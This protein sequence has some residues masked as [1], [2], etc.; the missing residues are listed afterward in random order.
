MTKNVLREPS[1]QDLWREEFG[2]VWSRYWRFLCGPPL[3]LGLAALLFPL[4][5]YRGTAQ[6]AVSNLL[7]FTFIAMLA[8]WVLMWLGLVVIVASLV[9]NRQ[10]IPSGKRLSRTELARVA[11][12]LSEYPD[13]LTK[14]QL[15]WIVS[16]AIALEGSSDTSPT[17]S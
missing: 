1:T 4:M 11:E 9:R 8:V 13:G 3:A 2:Y 6:S 17:E 12:M 15:E 16:K 14:R 7:V 10:R 5:V